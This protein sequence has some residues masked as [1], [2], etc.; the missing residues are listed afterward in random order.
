[1]SGIVLPV[2]VREKTGTSQARYTR[3]AG[4]IPGTL[5]GGGQAPVSIAVKKNEFLKAI[6]SGQLLAN[7]I[8]IRHDGKPQTVFARD[9]QFDPVKDFPMHFDFV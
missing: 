7:I 4:F 1:M 2:E 6:N 5:Y 8:T 3:S 9:V